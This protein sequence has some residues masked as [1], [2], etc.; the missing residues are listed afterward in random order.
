VSRVRACILIVAAIAVAVV[1]GTPTT[2]R[3]ARSHALGPNDRAFLEDLERRSFR[4]FEEQADPQTGH[5][6]DRARTDGSPHDETHRDVA[7]IAATGY[8]LAGLCIAAERGWLPRA[9]AA[10]RARTTIGFLARGMPHERGWFPHFVNARTGARAWNSEYSSIDT[11]LL[12]GGVLA[13][14]GCFAEDQAIRRDADAVYRRIDFTWMLNGDPALLSMGWK[15]ESGFLESRWNHYCELML[16]YL[17]AIGSPTHPIP[18]VS[19]YAWTRPTVTFDQH[20]FVGAADPLFV[21]QYSHAFVDFR[22]RRDTRSPHIDWWQNSID[23]T[24]AHKAFCLSISKQFPGYTDKIWGITAS[25]GPNGY[26][27]WGGP[28]AHGPIDGTVVP[29]AAG[30]SLMF[31][32][33]ITLP[34]LEAMKA[35]FGSKIY[36]RY[37]FADAFHPTTGWVNPDVLGIDLGITLLSAENLR[38][39]NVWRWVMLDASIRKALDSVTTKTAG[40]QGLRDQGARPIASA[41]VR[42]AVWWAP[43]SRP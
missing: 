35:Q 24:R 15:P 38:T 4:Y 18:A 16:L 10:A 37:S 30:G 6:R 7:S 34:A 26:Q 17:L 21:H 8:G 22:G 42:R 27:A 40:T 2:A 29:A 31:A 28:P 11:A 25:D 41:V 5:V 39:G 3:S 43:A 19:W 14:K 32:P 33:D 23:A 13:A 1:V 36:G 12:M 9:E 20:T